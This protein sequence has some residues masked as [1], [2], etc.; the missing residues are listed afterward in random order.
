ME[1]T[2]NQ[3]K[4]IADINRQLNNDQSRILSGN[5]L[6][7]PLGKSL[8]YV[9]PLFLQSRTEGIAPKP[10]LVKVILA[11]PSGNPVVAD[12]YDEAFQKLFGNGE[13]V[14]APPTTAEQPTGTSNPSGQV[15][16]GVPKG[17]VRAVLQM[18]D[19][20]D[21]ALRKGDLSKYGELVKQAAQKLRELSR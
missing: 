14:S 4:V 5:L 13:G 2:F 12:T 19:D 6:V 3:D 11:L 1:A 8:L 15:P 16:A 7:V 21:T 20:A 17:Q 18:L 9:E 10:K